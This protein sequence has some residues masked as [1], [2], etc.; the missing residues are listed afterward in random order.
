V[1]SNIAATSEAATSSSAAI[2]AAPQL[3][4]ATVDLPNYASAG[5]FSHT[6]LP[7]LEHTCELGAGAASWRLSC[8][9]CILALLQMTFEGYKPDR[10]HM[11]GVCR[12]ALLP[13]VL[14]QQVPAEAARVLPSGGGR[15]G[16]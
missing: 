12:C 7:P 14:R 1:A 5:P 4:A 10:V 2:P 9:R 8:N 3:A 13:S 6:W 15:P 11:F 16:A